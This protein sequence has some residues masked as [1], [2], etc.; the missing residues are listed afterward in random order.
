MFP[1]Q[2]AKSSPGPSDE[3]VRPSALDQNLVMSSMS[4]QLI[5]VLPSLIAMPRPSCCGNECAQATR[6]GDAQLVLISAPRGRRRLPGAVRRLRPSLLL[7]PISRWTVWKALAD[8]FGILLTASPAARPSATAMRSSRSRN[9]ARWDLAQERAS[10]S[11]QESQR[12]ATRRH[13]GN[14]GGSRAS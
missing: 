7:R 10:R 6:L 3:G 9:A 12:S 13:A 2:D 5:T 11:V 1:A 14:V 4:A 8:G